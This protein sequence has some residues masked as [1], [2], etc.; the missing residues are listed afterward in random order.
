[1]VI[2]PYDQLGQLW[3][4]SIL[5]GKSYV[6]KLAQPIWVN[7]FRR[8]PLPPTIILDSRNG[9]AL[10]TVQPYVSGGVGTI[11]MDY[12]FNYPYGGYPQDLTLYFT[13]DYVSKL[14]FVSL[15]WITPDGREINF[16]NFSPV[17]NLPYHLSED[18]SLRKNLSKYPNM[19]KWFVVGGYYPTPDF[20]L[21]FSDPTQDKPVVLRGT[22]TLRINVITFEEGTN[23]DAEFVLMGK[24]SGWAGTDYMRRDLLVPLLWGMPFALALGLIGASVT[25]FL[26]MIVAAMAAWY[27]GWLD[28]LIQR[29]IEGIMIL[30]VIAIGVIFYAYFNVGIWTFLGMI[31]LLNVFGSPTKSFRAAFLQVKEAP[32]IEAA[33][34]AGASDMR[35]ILHYMVPG[36][37]PLLVPQLIT[38]IPSYVFLEAT[39]GLFGIN[40][41]Y[42][43]WGKVI[44]DALW[45]GSAYG[46]GFWVLEPIFLLLLTGLGFAM[47]GFALER[48]L[49]PR[50]RDS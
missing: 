19:Q 50:L 3:N 46:S 25:T 18:Q 28:G 22:Y 41:L 36:I 12:V 24:V 5:T 34:A 11:T 31:A 49:N 29:L 30:P 48:I 14:P 40:S 1:V 20:Y 39:L 9:T 26:S 2:Y 8:D 4:S 17:T 38:L 44:Y 27:G 42:P 43:T 23:V 32:F 21:L 15:T 35:I 6:P 10:K 37:I 47:L 7:W 16:G 13:N 33:R 45:H